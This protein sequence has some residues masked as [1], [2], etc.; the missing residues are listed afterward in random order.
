MT[1]PLQP[2][3]HL[4][5]EKALLIFLNAGAKIAKTSADGHISLQTDTETRDTEI[6]VLSRL[7]AAGLIVRNAAQIVLSP[8]GREIVCQLSQ[9]PD[10]EL[11]ELMAGHGQTLSMVLTNLDESP[12]A[13]LQSGA[14]TGGRAFL[15][16]TEFDAGERIRSD[17]TR[18]MLLPRISANWTASVSAGRRAGESNGVETLTNS[19]LAARQRFEAATACL[20]QDLSGVVSDICCYLKGFE[21][22]ELERKW[23]KR[24]AKFMLKAG[25]AVLALHYWPKPVQSQKVRRWGAPDYRP[26]INGNK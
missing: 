16:Q 20:G 15:S 22:V 5:G 25:L 12:L 11:Q 18:A 23:P 6:P 14:R 17:F 2:N 24:S 10:L 1:S 3:L 13:A 26:D 4:Q 7:S 19:A 21:Q 9:R 8:T